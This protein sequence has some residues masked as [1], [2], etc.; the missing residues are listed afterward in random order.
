MPNFNQVIMMGHLVRDPELKYVSNNKPLCTGGI[1]TSEKWRTEGGE[2]KESVC[3]LD[4]TIWG[5]AAET[6]QKYTAKGAAVMLVGRLKFEQWDDKQSGQKR[7]KHVLNVDEFQ[8]LGKPPQR[9][10]NSNQTG[11]GDPNEPAF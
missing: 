4:F 1:A 2:T 5:K 10:D 9:R 6:F 8:F 3:F 7:S 11:F